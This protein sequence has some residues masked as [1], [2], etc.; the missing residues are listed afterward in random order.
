MLGDKVAR[1]DHLPTRK[2]QLVTCEQQDTGLWTATP[3][4]SP[5][6]TLSAFDATGDNNKQRRRGGGG[7][8]SSTAAAA[9][10][11][12]RD[13]S[14]ASLRARRTLTFG[15]QRL[16]PPPTPPLPLLRPHCPQRDCPGTPRRC[17][18][19]PRK[20]RRPQVPPRHRHRPTTRR[21]DRDRQT[22]TETPLPAPAA[23]AAAPWGQ[24]TRQSRSWRRASRRRCHLGCSGTCQ[25][26]VAHRAVTAPS[27]HGYPGPR[28]WVVTVTTT[29]PTTAPV[30]L[31]QRRSVGPSWGDQQRQ[32]PPVAVRH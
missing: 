11:A 12:C 25:P 28:S 30:L 22:P 15:R 24:S 27:R 32:L 17:R 9:M 8:G 7:G 16:V 31:R 3:P 14:P 4:Y 6:S 13:P 18:P 19:L 29:K 2:K 20:Q 23:A 21:C 5:T 1:P 26:R 10:V